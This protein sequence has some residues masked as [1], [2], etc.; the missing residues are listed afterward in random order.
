[1]ADDQHTTPD[2]AEQIRLAG[3]L[4]H[5]NF[6]IHCRDGVIGPDDQPTV[7]VVCSCGRAY[8]FG[9]YIDSDRLFRWLNDH[10]ASIPCPHRPSMQVNGRCHDCGDIVSTGPADQHA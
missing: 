1:M 4:P 5:G 2:P 9:H 7:Y 10:D 8:A 3:R 6:V